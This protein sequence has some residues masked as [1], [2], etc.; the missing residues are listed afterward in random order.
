MNKPFKKMK[1][2]ERLKKYAARKR[3]MLFLHKG[4][5]NWRDETI[6]AI[7]KLSQLFLREK[8]KR[9]YNRQEKEEREKETDEMREKRKK[10]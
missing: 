5:D 1:P 3:Y 6:F 8:E 7:L 2:V 10:M 4:R 9:K